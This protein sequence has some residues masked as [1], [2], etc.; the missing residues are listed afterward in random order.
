MLTWIRAKARASR[1]RY[2]NPHRAADE[3]LARVDLSLA[4]ELGYQVPEVYKCP[5][6]CGCQT[7]CMYD[8]VNAPSAR[9]AR[10][11]Q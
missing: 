1:E 9:R 3:T 8:V 2:Y 7:G 11:L 4:L 5:L 6:I 10:G